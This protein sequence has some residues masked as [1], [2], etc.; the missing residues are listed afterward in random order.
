[1]NEQ[2]AIALVQKTFKSAFD[3][4][5]YIHFL[6]NFNVAILAPWYSYCYLLLSLKKVQSGGATECH[7][8]LH[9]Q[10][11][12]ANLFLFGNLL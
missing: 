8:Q 3:K 1:M 5:G 12:R 10:L 11:H 7:V 2:Q 4:Q 6:K 9:R